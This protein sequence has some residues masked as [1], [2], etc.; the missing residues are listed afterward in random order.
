MRDV[1]LCPEEWWRDFRLWSKEESLETV[2]WGPVNERYQETTLNSIEMGHWTAR[3]ISKGKE[4]SFQE[5][6]SPSLEVIKQKQITA[7]QGCRGWS[8]YRLSGW[9]TGSLQALC[10]LGRWSSLAS[11]RSRRSLLD[12]RDNFSTCHWGQRVWSSLSL[13]RAAGCL[14]GWPDILFCFYIVFLKIK[15][16]KA[17]GEP[18]CSPS[19]LRLY[20]SPC[21][22]IVFMFPLSLPLLL[23]PFLSFSSFLLCFL[24]SFSKNCIEV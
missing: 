7:K 19:I 4:L 2:E 21:P 1:S 15:M 11:W 24:F 18:S 13:W 8:R 9:C 22:S 6:S 23:P 14:W 20:S 3:I 16:V 5:V 10:P 12:L 17:T